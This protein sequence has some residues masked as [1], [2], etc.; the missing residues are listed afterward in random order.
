MK[1]KIFNFLR[2][3]KPR[4][5]IC[6]RFHQNP[7]TSAISIDFRSS[8]KIRFSIFWVSF[9]LRNSLRKWGKNPKSEN[10]K[11]SKVYISRSRNA[12][13]KIIKTFFWHWMLDQVSKKKNWKK[14]FL[15]PVWNLKHSSFLVVFDIFDISE[16]LDLGY[17][18]IATKQ[19]KIDKNQKFKKILKN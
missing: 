11:F 10:L 14:L 12:I 16:N 17:V 15:R 9:S 19:W 4:P 18:Q 1:I 8:S 7:L 3:I 2:K 5:S 6:T 13:W